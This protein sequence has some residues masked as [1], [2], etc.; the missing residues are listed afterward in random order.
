[1]K[2]AEAEDVLEVLGKLGRLARRRGFHHS[3][4]VETVDD[5]PR[6][7]FEDFATAIL[8]LTPDTKPLPRDDL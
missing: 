7:E 1:M 3:W 5:K 8:A 4:I 6:L 2:L